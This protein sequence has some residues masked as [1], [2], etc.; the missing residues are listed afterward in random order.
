MVVKTK[1]IQCTPDGMTEEVCTKCGGDVD[2]EDCWNCGGEGYSHHDCGEDCCACIR[3][4]PNVT[5]DVCNGKRGCFRCYSCE[6]ED[7]KNGEL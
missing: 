7:K 5:C 4:E 6:L 1:T 3:P 2:W